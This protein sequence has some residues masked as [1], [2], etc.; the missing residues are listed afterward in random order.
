MRRASALDYVVAN[1]YDRISLSISEGQSYSRR[2]F[3]ACTLQEDR[4]IISTYL[5]MYNTH[6]KT[7]DAW[8]MLLLSREALLCQSL[9]GDSSSPFPLTFSITPSSPGYASLCSII[10]SSLDMPPPFPLLPPPLHMPP[11]ALPPSPP[12]DTPLQPPPPLGMLSLRHHPLLSWVCLFLLCRLPL[13]W[14]CFPLLCHPLSFSCGWPL[15][16]QDGRT[17]H[18]DGA[19]GYVNIAATTFYRQQLQLW[20]SQKEQWEHTS[21]LVHTLGKGVV[22]QAKRLDSPGSPTWW[23]RA[24]EQLAMSKEFQQVLLCKGHSQ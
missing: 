15:C 19:G 1:Y 21:T 22:A 9:Y 11:S 23:L 16:S 12:L 8:Q 17:F 13:L 18:S 6:E 5:Y 2:Q 14:V 20:C 7:M 24:S 4:T 10:P 3:S